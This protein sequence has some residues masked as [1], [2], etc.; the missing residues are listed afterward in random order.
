MPRKK[1]GKVAATKTAATSEKKT[2]LT[3]PHAK[4]RSKTLKDRE[5]RLALMGYVRGKDWSTEQIRNLQAIEQAL[6]ECSVV[7]KALPEQSTEEAGIIERLQALEMERF[8]LLGQLH[9][10][11]VNDYH[12]LIS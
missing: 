8:Q 11:R 5:N 1:A 9:G 12:L 6:E 7:L 10:N 2:P 3:Q 4:T